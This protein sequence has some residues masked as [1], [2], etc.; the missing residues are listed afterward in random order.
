MDRRSA[1]RTLIG[2]ECRSRW[3]SALDPAHKIWMRLPWPSHRVRPRF[4]ESVPFWAILGHPYLCGGTPSREM[5]QKWHTGCATRPIGG[6]AGV[7]PRPGHGRVRGL[8]PSAGECL[9]QA[10]TS[11]DV[12]PRTRARPVTVQTRGDGLGGGLSPTMKMRLHREGGFQTRLYARSA[13]GY[14]QRNSDA[15]HLALAMD[16]RSACRTLIGLECLRVGTQLWTRRIGFRYD[17]PDRDRRHKLGVWPVCYHREM[18]RTGRRD[19]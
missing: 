4:D 3:D 10:Q 7:P 2:L 19:R 13:K 16:R 6:G 8:G 17:C 18:Y 14:S 11:T 9:S 1:Y 5:A 12:L 15:S